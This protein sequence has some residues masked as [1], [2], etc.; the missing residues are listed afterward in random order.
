MD[1]I[2][3]MML[4]LLSTQD[5][6]IAAKT[7]QSHHVNKY[8]K[9]DPDIAVGDMVLVSNESQLQHLPKGRQK[10]AIKMVGPY[11]SPKSTSPSRITLWTSLIQGGT[12]PSML[13]T[14]RSIRTPTL[15]C[16]QTD[17]G[18]NPGFPLRNR[19]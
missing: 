3:N 1:F 8:Q 10:L 9:P 14:F 11:G 19:I 13:T 18:D 4:S 2:E 5:A 6:I 12:T 15:R 7:E 17:K 16:S